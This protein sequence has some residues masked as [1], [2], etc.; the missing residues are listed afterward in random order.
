MHSNSKNRPS[1]E[2]VRSDRSAL[3]RRQAM[4]SAVVT[5]AAVSLGFPRTVD[6]D[7]P[8]L[9]GKDRKAGKLVERT[10]TSDTALKRRTRADYCNSLARYGG[11]FSNSIN[12]LF[13]VSQRPHDVHFG[14]VVVGSGYGASVC[15][16]RL[17][18]H[19]RPEY[20]ICIRV[21]TSQH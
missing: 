16:A 20:R 15:A 6:G 7:K 8:H 10:R 4:K 14:V 3:S 2:V 19:L 9:E 13:R 5:T 18:K 1:S 21:I 12:N 17:A 11:K